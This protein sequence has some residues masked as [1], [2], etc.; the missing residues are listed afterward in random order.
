MKYHPHKSVLFVTFSVEEGLLLLSNPL[1]LAMI[2]SCLAR[3]QFLY[4]V[5]ICHFLVEATHIHMVLVVTNPDDVCQFVKYFKTESAHMI[6]RLLGRKKRTVWCE[7]YDSPV[8]L[9]FP[10]AV[11]A[12]SYLYANPAKD[13]L[14][15]S[16]DQYPGLSSWDMYQ[17]GELKKNW[18][19]L[20][21][22]AFT[23]LPR[24]SHNLRG[25][26][27]Y[28]EQILSST[29]KT[30]TF[31]LEPDAWME[32][33]GIEDPVD[34]ATINNSIEKRVQKLE[35]RA[36]LKRDTEKKRVIGKE[37]LINQALN[38]NYRPQ[39]TGTRTWC[40]T[41]KRSLRIEFIRFLKDLFDEARE[42]RK[43]WFLG[44]Y[45]QP[46]PLGLYPPSMPKLA[47]PLTLW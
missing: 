32:A 9:T 15:E 34:K 7:G 39:R 37:R 10:R 16:I 19:R 31:T 5:R 18:K 8:V 42:V 20:R 24:D 12:I 6:N 14:E 4:P 44:D 33:F 3:A 2:K 13:N 21:R 41:E 43:R 23:A 46:Y 40:L 22:P 38:T 29:K 28:A 25:Y 27:K 35:K 45:S 47:E 1:C 11:I 30:H 17:R 36:K 26:T